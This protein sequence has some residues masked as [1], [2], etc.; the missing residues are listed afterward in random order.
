[1]N[2]FHEHSNSFTI[3]APFKAAYYNQPA[4]YPVLKTT[5]TVFSYI[6]DHWQHK[7][8]LL[9]HVICK[10]LL[11][12][13]D[14]IIIL[15]FRI[16]IKYIK[17][18]Y[19][20]IWTRGALEEIS[21]EVKIL[22]FA[23][24]LYQVEETLATFYFENVIHQCVLWYFRRPFFKYCPWKSQTTRTGYFSITDG[25]RL[26]KESEQIICLWRFPIAGAS[27]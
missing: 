26:I 4:I 9:H 18:F 11:R 8:T 13:S 7:I 12:I 16:C 27:S 19:S 10:M 22:Y 14:I 15:P 6:Q 17:T 1:M 25:L 21:L 3:L 23:Q 20:K 2:L 5:L 24:C